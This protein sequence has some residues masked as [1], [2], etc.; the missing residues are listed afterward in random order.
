[1]DGR[2]GEKQWSFPI[3]NDLFPV[4]T[5]DGY[6][7]HLMWQDSGYHLKSLEVYSGNERANGSGSLDG[8]FASGGPVAAGGRIIF[9]HDDQVIA[10]STSTGNELWRY[11]DPLGDKFAIYD[12]VALDGVLLV[13]RVERVFALNTADKSVLW[14]KPAWIW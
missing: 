14:E 10:H 2:T 13:A 4:F 8:A 9:T 11:T 7:I 3:P 5:V 6:I 12:L 1:M